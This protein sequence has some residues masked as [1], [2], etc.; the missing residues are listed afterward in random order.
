MN[1]PSIHDG[2]RGAGDAALLAR[3]TRQGEICHVESN[4]W[5]HGLLSRAGVS[6]HEHGKL[7]S[8]RVITDKF[9]RL[10]V[11]PV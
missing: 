7:Y 9:N 3:F 1:T 5:T 10:Q 2:Y 11:A 8:I 6:K 4:D